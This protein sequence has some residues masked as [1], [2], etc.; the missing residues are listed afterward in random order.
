MGRMVCGYS[1]WRCDPWQ[2]DSDIECAPV[3]AKRPKTV[4]NPEFSY[5]K[6]L[7]FLVDGIP[8]CHDRVLNYYLTWTKPERRRK[9]DGKPLR[10][11]PIRQHDESKEFYTAQC[12][13]YGLN[14]Y[15]TKAVAK[16]HLLNAYN[17]GRMLTVPLSM[18]NKER[19]MK[20]EIEIKQERDTKQRQKREDMAEEKL[21]RDILEADRRLQQLKRKL[22][23]G[24]MEKSEEAIRERDMKR[25]IMAVIA[26]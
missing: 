15:K 13:H 12:V 7:G 23:E 14:P 1:G 25:A 18:V 5:D 11:P 8:R 3:S 26:A 9:L 10:P 17:G 4:C 22:A 20:L 19:Q 21:E 24:K 16:K 6:R 2:S